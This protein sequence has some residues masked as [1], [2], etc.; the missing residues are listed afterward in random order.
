VR[1]IH[2]VIANEFVL[3]LPLG[4]EAIFSVSGRR[5]DLA[6]EGLQN[7]Y[8]SYHH[9]I[10]SEENLNPHRSVLLTVTNIFLI[11]IDVYLD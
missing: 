10:L 7:L 6:F 5:F 8:L 11:S 4:G 3:C 1:D 9:K 2:Y